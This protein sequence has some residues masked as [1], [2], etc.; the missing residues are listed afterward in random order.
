MSEDEEDEHNHPRIKA[1]DSR[2]EDPKREFFF[3]SALSGTI[4]TSQDTWLIDSGAS[5]HMTSY[6]K[7]LTNISE[8]NLSS[9]VVLGDDAI[10]EVKRVG[11]TS[12]KL[13]SCECAHMNNILY[14]PGLKKNLISVSAL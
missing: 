7:D 3:I 10:Y 9:Q 2:K 5:K 4:S 13:D 6:K 14:V 8:K 11:S 1:K 12:F